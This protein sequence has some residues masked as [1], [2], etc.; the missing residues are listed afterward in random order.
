MLRKATALPLCIVTDNLW[1]RYVV[2]SGSLVFVVIRLP[3]SSMNSADYRHQAPLVS[4]ATGTKE[5]V[6]VLLTATFSAAAQAA[7]EVSCRCD[8]AHVSGTVII[9]FIPS[10]VKIPMVK[11]IKLKS[12]LEWLT[13]GVIPIDEGASENNLLETVGLTLRPFEIKRKFLVRRQR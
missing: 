7:V 11:N 3:R 2:S 1:Y 12:N 9:F 4:M 8:A 10:V 6:A 13:F 5:C